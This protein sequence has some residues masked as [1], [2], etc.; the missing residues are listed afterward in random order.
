MLGDRPVIV[1][2]AAYDPRWPR[3]RATPGEVVG[4][5]PGA[6]VIVKT[7]DSTV[8]LQDVQVDGRPPDIAAWPIGVR[9][10]VDAGAMLS[11]L[12]ARA[13]RLQPR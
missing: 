12:L 6:G 13:D 4:R 5:A 8:L 3:Y 10:G 9:L 11:T 7:G 1:W 2:R